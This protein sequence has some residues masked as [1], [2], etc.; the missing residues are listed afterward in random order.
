MQNFIDMG[1]GAVAMIVAYLV[2]LGV[3]SG[4]PAVWAKLKAWWTS[5]ATE[6]AVLKG[7]IASAHTKIAAVAAD[8]AT[9]KAKVGA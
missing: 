5:G 8:V 2:Y 6:L 7:D 3:T 9:V 4:A 1:I